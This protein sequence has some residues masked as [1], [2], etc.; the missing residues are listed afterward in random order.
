MQ[1]QSQVSVTD[2][3]ADADPSAGPDT[4]A[5]A[6]ADPNANADAGTECRFGRRLR[7]KCRPELR[8]NL[9]QSIF[10]RSNTTRRLTP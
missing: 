8:Y 9:I 10:A 4:D 6:K 5:D 2:A 1:I 3:D 7:L